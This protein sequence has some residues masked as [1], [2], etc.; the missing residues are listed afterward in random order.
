MGAL[1]NTSAKTATRTELRRLWQAQCG[2]TWRNW[3]G[4]GPCV[5]AKELLVLRVKGAEIKV[6]GKIELQRQALILLCSPQI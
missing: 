3:P 5:A 6:K 4:F 2:G 1:G